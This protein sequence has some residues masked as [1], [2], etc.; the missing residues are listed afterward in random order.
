MVYVLSVEVFLMVAGVPT[1]NVPSIVKSRLRPK[2]AALSV[3]T[4][5]HKLMYPMQTFARSTKRGLREPK[6][7]R[8]L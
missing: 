1:L 4:K 2:Y 8:S 7:R 3:P 5:W 6:S